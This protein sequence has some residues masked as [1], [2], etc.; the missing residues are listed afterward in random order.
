MQSIDSNTVKI[1]P[2]VTGDIAPTLNIW[3]TDVPGKE[4]FLSQLGGRFDL[5]LIA[6]YEGHLA[7]FLLAR[8][9]YSGLPMTGVAV[10]FFITVKPEYQNKGIGRLLI[11]TLKNNCKAAG[12]ET[13]RALVPQDDARIM[14]YFEKACF[15]RSNV[16]NL[17][18]PT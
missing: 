10:M 18:C 15:S 16:L 8:L 1:R 5:S 4:I 7:G 17:D 3:W 2:M 12:I 9:I 6:E 13:V 11:S 14:K